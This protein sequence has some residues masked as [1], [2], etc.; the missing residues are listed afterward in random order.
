M[1][2][3][4]HWIWFVVLYFAFFRGK[5]SVYANQKIASPV[6]EF[7]EGQFIGEFGREENGYV[8][9]STGMDFLDNYPFPKSYVTIK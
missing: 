3:S 7:Q 9:V 6:G 1:Q 4:I 2:L 5:K 8:Y